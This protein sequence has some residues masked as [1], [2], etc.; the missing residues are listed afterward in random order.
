MNTLPPNPAQENVLWSGTPSQKINLGIFVLCVVVA[1]AIIASAIY[2][3]HGGT[4]STPM[5]ALLLLPAGVAIWRWITTRSLVY[6]LTDQRLKMR[7]GVFSRVTDDIE[8]YRVKDS[9]F[10][11]PFLQ[12]MLGIG[13][14]TLRTTDDSSP[15]VVL[16][17]MN[18]PEPLWERIRALVEARRDAKGVREIDMNAEPGPH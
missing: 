15:H 2:L 6:T 9:H 11:Q 17:G 14:I 7:R 3:A 12:R 16:D 18:D 5:L 10:T 8:L 13:T 1:V 4:P